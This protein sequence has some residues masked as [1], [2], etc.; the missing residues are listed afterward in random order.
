MGCCC[1]SSST[2]TVSQHG[3]SNAETSFDQDDDLR[4]SL[5]VSVK[6]CNAQLAAQLVREEVISSFDENMVPSSELCCLCFAHRRV[7]ALIPCGHS[8]TCFSCLSN[9]SVCPICR[10]PFIGMAR[11][12]AGESKED[13]QQRL[14]CKH[15]GEFVLPFLFDGHQEVCGLRKLQEKR[16]LEEKRKE[17]VAG[18]GRVPATAAAAAVHLPAA[19][20]E[21]E[22][23]GKDHATHLQGNE[24]SNPHLG[25][26][27]MSRSPPPPSNRTELDGEQDS[28]NSANPLI[29]LEKSALRNSLRSEKLCDPEQ[30]SVK[31][32]CLECGK[33]VHTLSLHMV[34]AAPCGHVVLC[35][36]C[37]K[38]KSTCPLCCTT[39]EKW[40]VLYD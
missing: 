12:Y 4:K 29:P 23:E 17:E 21:E 11:R 10:N 33:L 37:A 31:T 32:R 3:R 13:P 22:T 36:K 27:N 28:K 25:I 8:Y 16:E 6:N 24:G 5:Q 7:C 19:A 9:V 2:R 26:A 30:E 1:S 20:Q 40:F 18:E 39:I 38:T 15:C 14:C 35:E 34:V